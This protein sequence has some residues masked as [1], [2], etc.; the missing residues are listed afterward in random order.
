MS[1]ESTPRAIS[2]AE[3]LLSVAELTGVRVYEV[4]GRRVDP[5]VHA[6]DEPQAAPDV[7]AR[8]TELSLETRMR[9]AIHTDD[10]EL[11]ADIGVEYTL[12]EPCAVSEAAMQEFLTRVGAMAVFPFVRESIFAT[13]NRL[14]VNAPVLGLLRAGSFEVGPP[15]PQADSLDADVS[16]SSH[17]ATPAGAR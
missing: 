13:A 1:E 7:M 2:S 16:H 14:G 5:G 3:E 17:P 15:Q 12:S 6:G 4:H 8:G 10:S 9:L 11:L